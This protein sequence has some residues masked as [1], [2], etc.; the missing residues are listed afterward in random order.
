MLCC[1]VSIEKQNHESKGALMKTSKNRLAMIV[2][3]YNRRE[4]CQRT[5]EHLL[6]QPY[7]DY[8][9]DVFIYDNNSTDSTVAYLQEVERTM[10]NVS[11]IYGTENLGTAGGYRELLREKIF[12]AGYD[13]IIKNDDDEYFP[14]TWIDILDFWSEIEARDVLMVGFK[15]IGT[16]DYFNGLKWVARHEEYMTPIRFGSNECYRSYIVP[17]PQICTEQGWQMIYDALSD[18]G[19]KF[20]G[21]DVSCAMKIKALGKCCLVVYNRECFH[22]QRWEDHPEYT[23]G[24]LEQIERVRGTINDMRKRGEL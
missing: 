4:Y 11:V 8:T 3:T 10:P 14:E 2:V 6:S 5:L 1:A 9:C 23:K 19:E 17:G 12:G 22:F 24:K 7:G 13:F 16:D 15:R 18:F 20:G 21:W